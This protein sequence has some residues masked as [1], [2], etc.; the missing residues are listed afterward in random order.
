MDK[1]C[2]SNYIF[3]I[4][5]HEP[6]RLNRRVGLTGELQF[7]SSRLRRLLLGLRRGGAR[8]LVHHKL[9]AVILVVTVQ[10]TER[11]KLGEF[12]CPG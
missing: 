9:I 12:G 1:N 6:V 11:L 4:L 7:E 2:V 10:A 5:H 3:E 8:R